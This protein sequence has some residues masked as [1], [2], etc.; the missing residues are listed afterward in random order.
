[1]DLYGFMVD[2]QGAPPRNYPVSSRFAGSKSETRLP[3]IHQFI[4]SISGRE[5]RT[6]A[7]T[8]IQSSMFSSF[9]EEKTCCNIDRICINDND[10]NSMEK[11][12][13]HILRNGLLILHHIAMISG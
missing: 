3:M 13:T 11:T 2:N 4:A 6:P 12:C 9:R 1:M 10:L 8:A 5:I 7:A